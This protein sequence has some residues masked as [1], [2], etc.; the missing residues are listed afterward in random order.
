MPAKHIIEDFKNGITI[1]ILADL[2]RK[3]KVSMIAPLYRAD[4]LGLVTTNQK[5]YLFQQF[6][7]LKIR[8]REPI[9]LDI[10]NPDLL[11]SGLPSTDQR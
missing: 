5:R 8:R 2:K 11:K 3:W 6:N 4:D 10:K 7:Q 1:P 9:K